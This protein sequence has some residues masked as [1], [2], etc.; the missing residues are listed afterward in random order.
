MTDL[1]ITRRTL[2]S[3]AG[4]VAGH[5]EMTAGLTG[6]VMPARAQ[7]LAATPTMRGRPPTTTAP[8]RRSSN[9]LAAGGFWMTGTGVRR[10]GDGAPFG[11]TPHPDLGPHHRGQRAR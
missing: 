11:R 6:L 7:S 1:I 2:L 4:A 9:A 8:A 10:A 3:A 5:P